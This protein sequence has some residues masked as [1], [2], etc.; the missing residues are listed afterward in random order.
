MV[1]SKPWNWK[2]LND[3]AQRKMWIEPA[4]ESYYLINRWKN[5]QKKNFLDIGCGLRKA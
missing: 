3:E 5:Q 4:I 2:M 1:E